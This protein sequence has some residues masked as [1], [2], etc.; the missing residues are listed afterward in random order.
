MYYYELPRILIRL[1]DLTHFLQANIIYNTSLVNNSIRCVFRRPSAVSKVISD[2]VSHDFNLVKDNYYFLFATG[3]TDKNG[4]FLDYN[5][6][7]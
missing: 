3:A 4:N 2:G 6:N 7:K 5:F 1:F